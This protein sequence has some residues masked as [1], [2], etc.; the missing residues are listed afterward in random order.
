METT[1]AHDDLARAERLTAASTTAARWYVRYLVVYGVAS[2][3]LAAAY[4]FVGDG[5]ITT[6]VTMPLWAVILVGLSVWA[7]RQRTAVRGFGAIHGAVIGVWA[8][9]WALTVGLGT[10]VLAGVWQWFVGGG[11]VMAGA[12]FAGAYVTH[13]RSRA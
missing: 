7:A 3:A 9:A 6:V 8:A 4:A 11:V 10:T 2:F 12:A 1:D 13:R 5:L